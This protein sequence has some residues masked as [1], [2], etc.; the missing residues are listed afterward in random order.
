MFFCHVGIIIG[1]ISYFLALESI[2]SCIF[3]DLALE[4]TISPRSPDSSVFRITV[5][6]Y[7]DI[8]LGVCITSRS[9]RGKVKKR[10]YVY[11]H[12]CTHIYIWFF[13]YSLLWIT[14]IPADISNSNLTQQGL[15]KLFSFLYFTP[16]SYSESPDSYYL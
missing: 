1:A 13:I 6:R 11:Q 16:F 15:F 9:L 4:S 2:L 10:L 5:L 7:Q 8:T 12:L 3:P 14:V